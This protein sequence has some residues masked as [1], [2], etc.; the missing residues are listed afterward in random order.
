MTAHALLSASS[1]HRWLACPGS[2]ALSESLPKGEQETSFYAAEGTLAH[3]L[4]AAMLEA[5]LNDNYASTELDGYLAA[6]DHEMQR[7]V[8][9]YVNDVLS[10]PGEKLIETRVVFD[11]F[12]PGGFGTADAL[13]LHDGVMGVHDLKYGMGERVEA[14]NNPQLMLYA[15]G[16]WL[17]YNWLYDINAFDLVIHQPR[18]DHRPEWRITVEDLLGWAENVLKPGALYT[19]TP[20]APRIPGEKQCRWCPAKGVC[21]E[22]A[23]AMLDVALEGFDTDPVVFRDQSLFTLEDCGRV[24]GYR[25]MFQNWF[26]AVEQRVRDALTR[27][28]PVP[29]WK[30]V[31]GRSSRSWRDE[32]QA[33]AEL[34]KRLTKDA[35]WTRKIITVAQAEKAIGKKTFVELEGQVLVTEGAPTLA[36][37]SS[38]KEA[39]DINPT[40]GFDINE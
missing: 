30:F 3:S 1:S 12:V 40:S 35:I 39:I 32:E 11:G 24:L 9:V 23:K 6:T 14:E 31:S 22:H 16:A 8:G 26:D 34:L 20:G 2:I 4:A 17:E 13:V 5:A 38:K 19:L 21:P 37:E 27:G 15:L 7:F 25:K 28:E 36:P 33:A 29:G 10:R 18:L